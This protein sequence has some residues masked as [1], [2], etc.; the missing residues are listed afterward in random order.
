MA[1]APAKK[2]QDTLYEWEGKDRS[3]KIVKGE[4]RAGGEAMVG[5]DAGDEIREFAGAEPDVILVE[6]A[7]GETPEEARH[8]IFEHFSTRG[9]DRAA[10]R[11]RIGK[12]HEVVLVSARAMEKKQRHFAVVALAECELKVSLEIHARQIGR[13]ET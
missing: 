11:H 9:N 4:M 12:A 13:A 7:F 6:Q 2:Q 8:A 10:G 3:G 5:G 1:T